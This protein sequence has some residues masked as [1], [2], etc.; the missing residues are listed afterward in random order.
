M[1]A[2][3]GQNTVPIVQN[4]LFL[5]DYVNANT[6]HSPQFRQHRCFAPSRQVLARRIAAACDTRRD[7]KELLRDKWPMLHLCKQKVNK[8]DHAKLMEAFNS[9]LST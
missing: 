2:E 6:K 5:Y 1:Y 3:G 7:L 4:W 8:T 9:S